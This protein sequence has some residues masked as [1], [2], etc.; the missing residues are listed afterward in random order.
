M[1]NFNS[2]CLIDSDF[3][4]ITKFQQKDIIPIMKFKI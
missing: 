4:F 1:R 3:I 2:E